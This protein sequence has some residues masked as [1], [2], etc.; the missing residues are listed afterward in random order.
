MR[1]KNKISPYAHTLKPEIENYV[2]QKEWEENTLVDTEPQESPSVSFS[3]TTTPQV[4]KEKRPRKDDSPS[5]TEVSTEDFQVYN[6]KPKT[7]HATHMSGEEEPYS[8]TVIE[9]RQQVVSTSSSKKQTEIVVTTQTPQ[10]YVPLSIFEK[11]EMIK[12]KN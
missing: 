8:A 10:G 7:T 5:I 2:N 3:L 4:P 11:Y 12:K 6:K 1:S 9:R